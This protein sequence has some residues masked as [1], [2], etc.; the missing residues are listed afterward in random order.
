M[1]VTALLLPATL[2]AACVILSVLGM[3]FNMMTLGGM[4]AAV[5][6]VV[7]DSVVMLEHL[8]RRFREAGEGE[9]RAACC[10]SPPAR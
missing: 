1:L 8:V 5:G 2:G 6:L 4:A 9:G 3:S 10:C 7:D